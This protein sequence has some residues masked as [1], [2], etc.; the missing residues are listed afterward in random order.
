[1]IRTLIPIA[2]FIA[3]IFVFVTHIQPMFAEIRS[4]QDEEVLLNEALENSKKLEASWNELTSQYQG[5]SEEDIERLSTFLPDNID[6]VKLIIE[7]EDL[8]SLHN[9]QLESAN[10]LNTAEASEGE[11]FGVINLEI[12]LSGKYEDFVLFL[13]HVE[14]SLRLIDIQ[15]IDFEA[16]T[17]EEDATPE[18]MGSPEYNYQVSLNTYWLK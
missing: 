12:E 1:M 6:N 15:S 5:Y 13:E 11:K 2:I 7:I 10:S 16:A 8:A 17:I 18:E 14:K 9:L 3:A 4:L